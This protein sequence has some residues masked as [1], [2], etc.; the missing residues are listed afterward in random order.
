MILLSFQIFVVFAV[1]LAVANAGIVS[2]AV[3]APVGSGTTLQGPST[4]TT[5]VGPDGSAIVGSAPGGAISTSV[6]VGYAAHSAAPAVVAAAPAVVAARYATPTV[7]AARYAAPAVVSARYAAPGVVSA[8][9]AVA[10]SAPVVANHAR[11]VVAAPTVYAA[12]APLLAANTV[13]SHGVVA[14]RTL[15]ASPLTASGYPLLA[16]GSGLEG[17][18]VHDYTEKLYDDGSYKGEIY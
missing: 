3:V 5:V 17:Q 15:V 4:R 14:G 18:Y 12:H 2:H 10:Y 13:V 7:V 16:P 1:A 9:A 6:D 8:P 11:T